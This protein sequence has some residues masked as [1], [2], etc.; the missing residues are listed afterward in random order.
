MCGISIAWG[1]RGQIIFGHFQARFE[2]LL[3]RGPDSFTAES[4]NI[5]DIDIA[6][7]FCRLAI[8][9][10]GI[11]SEQPF[12]LDGGRLIL[13]NG[14]IYN[15]AK[16]QSPALRAL[17]VSDSDC[18][19]IPKLLNSGMPMVE[20]CRQ[21]DGDFAIADINPAAGTITVARDPY[22]VRPLFFAQYENGSCAIASEMKG[23]YGNGFP[24]VVHQ[25]TPGMVVEY[26]LNSK[27]GA[28]KN[29][30]M[31]HQVPWLKNPLM[32]CPIVSRTSV[33][34]AFKSSVKKRMARNSTIE[35]GACLSGGLDSSVVV[36]MAVSFLSRDDP[37]Y[38][39]KT[40]SIGMPGSP[41]LAAAR[42]VANYLHTDHHEITVT[43]DQCLDV[44]PEVIRAIESYDVTTVR[45][46]VGNYLVGQYIKKNCPR[47]KVVLNGD[48]A[49]E[50]FGGY[51]YMRAA[52]SDAAFET[53]T[54]RLLENIHFYDVLRSERCMAAHGLESRS[55]FLDRQ[56]VSVVRSI[57][58]AQLR[59]SAEVIE[60]FVLR[61]VF[62]LALPLDIVMRPKEAFSDGISPGGPAA[63]SW[64]QI[65]RAKAKS[66]G[67]SEADW[68]RQEFLLTYCETEA[69]TIPEQWMPRFVTGAT[70]PSARTILNE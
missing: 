45:A 42:R 44:I 54:T 46:S 25:V 22:G 66:C 30:F 21:L 11:S 38:N 9:G 8:Q 47:V 40:F 14:E 37:T 67:L 60:K 39:L 4:I 10:T 55:P 6:L 35:I 51:K 59:P 34:R 15:A 32:S 63:L 18:V 36:A 19:I 65:T 13:V 62:M 20:V 2:H 52:P 70:D 53:E 28:K 58:T 43:P 1:S 69:S 41:D 17:S 5:N 56:F 49:D 12:R 33:F 29:A 23:L 50:L 68:Y 64:Y 61:S 57:P 7:G 3:P 24:C 48:G 31:F 26:H 16:L 27:A